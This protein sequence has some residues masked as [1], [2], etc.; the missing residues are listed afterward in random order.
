MYRRI[1]PAPANPPQSAPIPLNQHQS[2]L[3]S[4]LNFP[5][6]PPIP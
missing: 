5:I 3:Y 4:S 2:T 6:L 1:S